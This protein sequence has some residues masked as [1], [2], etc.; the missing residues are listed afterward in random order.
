MKRSKGARAASKP[1]S[2]DA[3]PRELGYGVIGLGV[4][5]RTHVQA[6][7]HA[8]KSGVPCRLVAVSDRDP[9][10]LDG[11]TLE[12]GNLRKG[13]AGEALFDPTVVRT[14]TDPQVLFDDPDVRAVSICT[15]TDTHV[16]LAL[17]ALAAGKHV[18]VEK[19]IALDPRQVLRVA[20]AARAAKRI[21]M[22]AMCMRFWPCWTWLEARVRDGEFGAVKSAVFQ[23]L[24]SP[25]AWAPGFYRDARQTG[26]ALADLH[27]HDADFVH[28]LFGR[29][30]A[31][32]VAGDLD[33]VTTLY[34]FA[35]GPKHVVAEGG[36]DHAPGFQFT[37]RY[38]VVFERATADYCIARTDRLR[39]HQDGKTRAVEMGEGDGYRGEMRHFVS[40]VLRGETETSPSMEEAAEVAELLVRERAALGKR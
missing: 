39:V 6:L 22:P 34:R 18:L 2:G 15:H 37:M 3:A 24:A 10:R 16:E 7:E 33:H 25:P 38:V 5:G 23:R 14:A 9:A 11:R 40:A 12:G 17:R 13:R 19:P 36:W 32:E 27:I 26:G 21:A 31:V 1:Q 20:K 29:P 28:W 30:D 35:R 4:M 8:R